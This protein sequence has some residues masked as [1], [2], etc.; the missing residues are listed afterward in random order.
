MAT[1]PETVT[2]LQIRTAISMAPLY[3]SSIREGKRALESVPNNAYV[4][5]N[6]TTLRQYVAELLDKQ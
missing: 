3:V 1:T 4:D 5:R 6:G 2:D